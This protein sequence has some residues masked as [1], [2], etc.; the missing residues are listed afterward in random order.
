MGKLLVQGLSPLIH[1]CVVALVVYEH[2]ITLQAEVK[3]LWRRQASAVSGLFILNRYS[4]LIWTV[5]YYVPISTSLVSR[6]C[7]STHVRFFLIPVLEVC[8]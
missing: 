5:L 7:P 3:M 1:H 4:I 6:H 8:P 2:I